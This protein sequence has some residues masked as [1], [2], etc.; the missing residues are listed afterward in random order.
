MDEWNIPRATGIQLKSPCSNKAN[1]C[2]EH[3]NAQEFAVSPANPSTVIFAD[4]ATK[5]GMCAV[6]P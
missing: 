4:K 6:D 5:N 2:N 1:A 3:C